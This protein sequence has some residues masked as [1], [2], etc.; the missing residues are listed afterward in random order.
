MEI[1]DTE[2]LIVGAGPSGL[3]MACQLALHGIR[4]RIIDKKEG[5]T[6][7]SGALIVQARSVE[8]FNRMGIAQKLIREGIIAHNINILYNGKPLIKIPVKNIGDGLSRFPYL[9]MVK[10]SKT[11]QI[12]SAFI[13]EYGF[14]IER[15]F[16]FISFMQDDSVVT[17]QIKDPDGKISS[18]KS[19]YLIAADGGLSIIRQ[20]LNIPFIGKAHE[21]SL[22]IIDCKADTVLPETDI[23]FSFSDHTI[24][25]FFPLGNG[26]WR[27]DGTVHKVLK[28]NKSLTFED[29]ED[30][31]SDSTRMDIQLQKPDWFSVFHS[32]HHYASTYQINRCYLL[33]DAAH[34]HSPIG[35]QGMNTGL[36]DAFNLG[37][38]LAFVIK[39]IAKTKLTDTYTSERLSVAKNI[40]NV[41]DKIFNLVAND[42]FF[43]KSVRTH[44]LPTFIKTL[45]PLIVSRGW[46]H[47]YLF[48]SISELDIHYRD[49]IL[50]HQPSIGLFPSGS[51]RPGDR[52]PFILYEENGQEVNIQDKVK[53]TGYYL[54][55]ISSKPVEQKIIKRI[56]KY[57]FTL[58]IEN[59]FST[60]DNKKL[61]KKLNIRN[62]Y[63]L[64]RPDMYIAFLSLNLNVRALEDYLNLFLNPDL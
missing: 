50:S 55:I 58:S 9:L 38:K 54:F 64:V 32:R 39:G 60:P 46:I 62:G 1:N 6:T 21:K 59:I 10:Q 30:Q 47:R 57:N 53:G 3:M 15:G 35:A 61:F 25:G 33:G 63:L 31:F 42:D 26:N 2:V 7:N 8:L 14:E 18:V 19:R 52:L 23:S 24:S 13:K 45:F 36:Q 12:L 37:W 56:E 4:F 44:L 48:K 16:E 49:S 22:F 28:S 43:T 34:V 40:I 11:E 51:V 20:Q 29:V 17:S 41:T 5:P 27:I